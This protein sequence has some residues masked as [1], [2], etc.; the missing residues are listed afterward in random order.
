[1]FCLFTEIYWSVDE[2]ILNVNVVNVIS[3]KSP[4]SVISPICFI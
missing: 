4:E 3:K 2:V 1:M